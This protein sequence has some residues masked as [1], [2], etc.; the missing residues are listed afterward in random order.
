MDA[1]E[2]LI[3]RL[4]STPKESVAAAHALGDLG[5]KRAVDPLLT[6]I[7]ETD[8]AAVRDAAAVALRDIGDA[9][10]LTSI[11]QLVSDPRTEGHRG[12]LVYA[13][14]GFDCA[15]IVP[16][17]VQLV[18]GGNFEVSREAFNAIESIE[19]TVDEKDWNSSLAALRDALPKA[20]DSKK[21]LLKDLL[22]LFEGAE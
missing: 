19:G 6:L 10:A 3:S 7:K 4:R 13:L 15:G 11:L 14:G 9:R 21:Q 16:Q 18:I 22:A 2:D 17:L 20:D 12:T 8:N 5:D 1:L